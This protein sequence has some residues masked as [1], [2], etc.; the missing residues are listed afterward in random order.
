MTSRE[1]ESR[2]LVLAPIGRDGLLMSNLLNSKGVDCV[3]LPTS[4]MIRIESKKGVGVVV[5]AEEALTLPEIDE[6]AERISEQPSWSDFPLILLTFTGEVSRES[7]RKRLARQPLRNVI[8]LERP[9]RPETFVSTVQA[10]LHSRLRQ[11]QMRDILDAS[12]KTEAALRKAEKL[13]V[14]GRLAASIAHEINNPLESITNL[15][16]LI[17]TANSL[18]DAKKHTEVAESE[19][20]RVSEIVTHMLRFYRQPSKPA[21]VQVPEILESALMLYKRRLDYSE[22]VVEKDFRECSPIMAM[23]GELR[24]VILN[25]ISNASDA[26]GRVGT[27]KIRLTNAREHSN[28]SRLGIRL[29][30][31]DTGSGIVPNIRKT[32]FE[33]F[34]STKGNLGTGLGLWISSEIIRKHG[35]TIQVKTRT[36]PPSTGTVFSVFLP[37]AQTDIP[38]AALKEYELS[39][40]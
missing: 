6:W 33:P 12:D 14:A 1:H 38:A 37:S 18:Q 23:P 19:L 5:L 39:D 11:Y 22:I 30:I 8:L 2:V 21:Y 24:Q 20:A 16:Y 36:L 9:V 29:T 35:G 15:L 28:G 3:S 13:V 25:L 40:P 27:L 10:A 26:I 31:A 7:Q 17:S 32:L 4:E 34:V